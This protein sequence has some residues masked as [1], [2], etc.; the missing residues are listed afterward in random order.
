MKEQPKQPF[1]ITNYSFTEV[2]VK[3]LGVVFAVMLLLI[4]IS[5]M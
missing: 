4:G 2:C 5:L 3:I 1:K